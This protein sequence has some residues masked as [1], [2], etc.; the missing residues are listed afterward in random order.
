MIGA[1]GG[2]PGRHR[3]LAEVVVKRRGHIEEDAIA[4]GTDQQRHVLVCPVTAD[5]ES[6]DRPRRECLSATIEGSE[7][8][9]QAEE[10]LVRF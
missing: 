3:R 4:L 5:T 8:L 7:M 2:L 1:R 9:A 6:I 10:R